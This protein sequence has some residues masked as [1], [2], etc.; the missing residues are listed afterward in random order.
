VVKTGPTG[1]TTYALWSTVATNTWYK[2]YCGKETEDYY[3]LS[4]GTNPKYKVEHI[5]GQG[6]GVEIALQ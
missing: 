6:K 5:G 1:A 4:Q 3:A 2:T